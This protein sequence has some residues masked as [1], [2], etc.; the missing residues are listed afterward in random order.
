MNTDKQK[1]WIFAFFVC[2]WE[3]ETSVVYKVL[4]NQGGKKTYRTIIN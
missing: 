3:R 1:V 2:E 4:Q